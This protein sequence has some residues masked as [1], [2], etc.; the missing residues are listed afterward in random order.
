MHTLL[1]SKCPN[2]ALCGTSWHWNV[3]SKEECGVKQ[4][5]RKEQRVREQMDTA[6]LRPHRIGGIEFLMAKTNE[7]RRR[8]AVAAH[9]REEPTLAEDVVVSRNGER[10]LMFLDDA[11]LNIIGL[12]LT[13]DIFMTSQLLRTG[14]SLTGA[15][16]TM[17][18]WDGYSSWQ[19]FVDDAKAVFGSLGESLTLDEPVRL[20]RGLGLPTAPDAD[21]PDVAGISSH[22]GRGFP[23]SVDFTEAGFS[24][25]ATDPQTALQYNGAHPGE[26]PARRQV[27]FELEAHRGL[28][29]PSEE[30]RSRELVEHCF[31]SD[32]LTNAIGQVVFPPNTQ[33]RIHSVESTSDHGVPLV[34]MNQVN[35]PTA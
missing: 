18:D 5:I 30:H 2:P 12:M 1:P 33:W 17:M 28:C 11:D 32:F 7:A 13:S 24:F 6:E 25:A 9:V 34:R 16:G 8:D 22:L 20:Y 27:L 15:A 31:G 3:A 21:H 4:A 29:I 10:Q 26:Y 35:G 14:K 19:H 23:W